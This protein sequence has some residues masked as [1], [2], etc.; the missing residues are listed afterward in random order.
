MTISSRFSIQRLLVSLLC[1]L[2][3][4]P[5]HAQDK[6]ASTSGVI[7]GKVINQKGHPVALA[8][9]YAFSNVATIGAIRYVETDGKGKFRLDRLNWGTYRVFAK[10]ES[11]DYPDISYAFY[12]HHVV[13]ATLTPSSPLAVVTIHV[14]PPCG[15]LQVVSIADAVTGKIIKNASIMLRRAADP[16]LYLGLNAFAR[17]IL[18]PSNTDVLVQ[19]SA[20]GYESWP[21]KNKERASGKLHLRPGEV[22]NL[23]VELQPLKK[24]HSN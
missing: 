13:T 6:V 16:H 4:A 17:P 23:S 15:E 12:S 19:V 24:Q 11:A 18:I 22:Y 14:G 7:E 9:A 1:C 8:Q 20:K 21:S 3:L 10:K 2:C 5:V